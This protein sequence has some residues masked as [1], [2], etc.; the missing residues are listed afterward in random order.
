MSQICKKMTL[1]SSF[2]Y[3]VAS[4]TRSFP[5]NQGHII[6]I[7]SYCFAAADTPLAHSTS[8]EWSWKTGQKS[9][10]FLLRFCLGKC[11]IM[12]FKCH[13]ILHQ[14]MY[15]FHCG[16]CKPNRS[17]Y[18]IMHFKLVKTIIIWLPL[19]SYN[20]A[21]HILKKTSLMFTS[22]QSFEKC[23]R[24]KKNPTKQKTPEPSTV[25]IFHAEPTVT[26]SW[27]IYGADSWQTL[28]SQHEHWSHSL[29]Y[30]HPFKH[31]KTP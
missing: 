8:S 15:S 26:Y 25:L 16:L 13:N 2:L 9:Y 30:S 21:F 1:N 19:K 22:D 14:I 11:E 23:L 20:T 10:K 17:T 28:A 31:V 27:L 24:L 18:R 6:A 4:Y 5:L 3:E 29:P 12:I 7:C